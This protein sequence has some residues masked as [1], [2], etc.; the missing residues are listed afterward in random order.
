M[1]CHYYRNKTHLSHKNLQRVIKQTNKSSSKK[2]KNTYIQISSHDRLLHTSAG[3]PTICIIHTHSIS[4]LSYRYINSR[5]G[6]LGPGIGPEMV[7]PRQKWTRRAPSRA[8][9]ASK[10]DRDTATYHHVTPRRI[11]ATEFLTR[12]HLDS[13]LIPQYPYQNRG[14]ISQKDKTI[15]DKKY[16]S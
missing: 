15:H 12:G 8:A 3:R 4:T 2:S 14:A 9:H 7:A 6:G 5:V 11:H 13:T 16:Q 1:T 10:R